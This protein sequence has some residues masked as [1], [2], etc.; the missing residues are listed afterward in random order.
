M[1]FIIWTISFGCVLCILGYV[2]MR[3]ER[4]TPKSNVG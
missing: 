1:E 4:T 2:K 3:I